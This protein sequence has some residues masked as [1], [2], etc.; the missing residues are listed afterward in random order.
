MSMTT[1]LQFSRSAGRQ[2]RLAIDPVIVIAVFGLLLVGL[3]MVTSASLTVSERNG[4]APYFYFARQF[5]SVVLGCTIA[6]GVLA[7][8]I[9]VWKRF[10]PYLLIVSFA[11]LVV[12]LVPGIGH[13]V[14][15][16]QRWIRIGPLNLQPSEVAR[17]LLVTYI[18]I[19][20]VRHQTELRSS[21]HGFWKPLAVLGG[22]RGAPARRAGFRGR[23]RAVH[24][25]HR[26]AVRRW[27]S[28]ARLPRR[29]RRWRSGRRRARGDQPV[30]PEA[31][32]RLRR[33]LV[34]PV[35]QRLPA[36]PVA[37]R[38]RPRGMVRG[39]TRLE[40]PEALLPA[41]GTHRL[42]VRGAGGGVRAAR[43]A[44][45]RAR[46]PRDR[47]AK[48][49]ALAPGG[50]R[51][52]AAA[53]LHRRRLRRVDRPAGLPEHR[54]QHGAPAHQG[55]HPPAPVVRPLEHAGHARMDRDAAARPPRSRGL[56]QERAPARRA[57]RNEPHGHDHGRRH[58]R[59]RVPGTRDRRR[60][61]RGSRNCL[62]RHRAR[63]RGTPRAGRRLSG[64]MDR[65]RGPARQGRRTLARR[66]T[67][68][69]ARGCPGAARAAPPPARRR[70]GTRR[71]RVRP[72]RHRGLARGHAARGPRAECGRRAHQPLAR[73]LRLA[74]RGRISRQLPR[75]SRGALRRQPGA[76]GDRGAA[77]AAPAFRVAERDAAPVRVRRQPGR[78][79]AQPPGAGGRGAACPRPDVRWY[80][81]RRARRTA[82]RRRRPI[83]RPG[84]QADV[85]AFV[86]DMA[87][88]YAR[89]GPGRV[90]R[91][92]AD[93]R[94]AGRRRGRIDP[95]AV[96]R[97]RRRSPGAQRRMARPRERRAGRLRGRPDG[98]RAREPACDAVRQRA[99]APAR[100][101]RGRTRARRSPTPR[102]AWPSSACWRNGGTGERPH[103]PRRPH[104]PDRHRRGR[105]GRHRRGARQPRL[106]GAGLRPA[107]QRGHRAPRVDGRAHL[108]RPRRGA[109]CGRER[110]GRFLGRRRGQSGT[111]RGAGGAHAGRAARRN[112]GRAH[113]LPPGH[114]GRR[115]RTA[116]PRL[117]ASSP[118]CSPRAASTRRS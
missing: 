78:L 31:H 1:A 9:A 16:S 66:A 4:V 20:A 89:G 108:R 110:R 47:A 60:T 84:M 38:G 100:D 68:A 46:L 52:D 5:L 98:A 56:R 54:R 7:V 65:G 109:G 2:Q 90:A 71:L 106:C 26:R 79:R 114:R 44:C 76:A 72:G 86:E 45:G 59:P 95:R 67:H 40:H 77:A 74:C 11:L 92:R 3:V 48:P 30:S 41:R 64:G 117:R 57:G 96:P 101:G 14:N 73:A 8:P 13:E 28:H 51:R 49:Q 32:P 87:A 75:R 12:V 104:P 88:A 58:R 10:A 6:A 39:R 115:A 25:R 15:G 91:R 116:R 83:A 29:V 24:H 43:R 36:H 81:T 85:R 63:H 23:G 22:G 62:A 17:W 33:P 82:R 102:A 27:R 69:A 21:A 80:C 55:P 34:R 97:G 103:A 94:R 35:R 105:H 50:R 37:D 42:R 93:R 18:A 118:R 99:L 113:A 111:S 53:R 112:A 70:A 61:A 19:F 107:R